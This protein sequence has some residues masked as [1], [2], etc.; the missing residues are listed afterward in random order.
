MPDTSH[1]TLLSDKSCPRT[2]SRQTPPAPS[3]EAIGKTACDL[4]HASPASSAVSAA[5]N[6]RALSSMFAAIRSPSTADSIVPTPSNK[7]GTNSSR[8]TTNVVP[9]ALSARGKSITTANITTLTHGCEDNKLQR[10]HAA[11]VDPQTTQ[12]CRLPNRR[13]H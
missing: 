2:P 13:P 7:S 12:L 1:H 6:A 8:H 4:N 10:S 11:A 5:S 9:E 3:D